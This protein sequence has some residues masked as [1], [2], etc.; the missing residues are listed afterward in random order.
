MVGGYGRCRCYCFT[1]GSGG[2]WYRQW[3]AVDMVRECL[4]L[5]VLEVVAMAIV[6]AVI[7]EG[8]GGWC[9]Q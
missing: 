7:A 1:A 9:H 3:W 8:G 6:V 4:P 2:G 5:T